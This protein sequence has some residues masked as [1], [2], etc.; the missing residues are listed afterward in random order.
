[1]A[2]SDDT[3]RTRFHEIR[4]RFEQGN[5]TGSGSAPRERRFSTGPAQA[6]EVT[7]TIQERLAALEQDKRERASRRSDQAI[8]I[9]AELEWLKGLK[10][11]SQRL[12]ALREKYA[13]ERAEKTNDPAVVYKKLH[14]VI[15][16]LVPTSKAW[17][18]ATYVWYGKRG[19]ALQRVDRGIEKVRA[20]LDKPTRI[21]ADDQTHQLLVASDELNNA[22]NAW[23][24]KKLK[25]SRDKFEA[26]ALELEDRRLQSAAAKEYYSNLRY[27][28]AVN[29]SF[30]ALLTRQPHAKVVEAAR[31]AEMTA[32]FSTLEFDGPSVQLGNLANAAIAGRGVSDAVNAVKALVKEGAKEV[33]AHIA[34]ELKQ[35]ALQQAV[36]A[37]DVLGVL[38]GVTALW[39]AYQAYAYL[40]TKQNMENKACTRLDD[41]MVLRMI[42]TLQS[43]VQL[44]CEQAAESAVVYA[45]AAATKAATHGAGA[46]VAEALKAMNKIARVVEQVAMTAYERSELRDI[47]AIDR[48]RDPQR[49]AE[50]VVSNVTLTC[51]YIRL[52]APEHL[53]RPLSFTLYQLDDGKA[54]KSLHDTKE[55]TEALSD[56]L[57][58][59]ECADE[60]LTS[61]N[62]ELKNLHAKAVCTTPLD[63]ILAIYSN[64]EPGKL[65]DMKNVLARKSRNLGEDLRQKKENTIASF[66]KQV[67]KMAQSAS[68]LLATASA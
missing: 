15:S 43:Q 12:A 38:D 25:V 19:D 55:L 68:Q 46:P 1:M 60:I 57:E 28:A 29:A 67:D 34:L 7:T 50:G 20:L 35:E 51:Y 58:L 33:S 61:W 45:A 53:L 3:P 48:T 47:N 52:A 31:V 8:A 59:K 21:K 26:A 37:L 44:Q 40:K 64:V 11:V 39:N 54:F 42:D 6:A 49:F 23:A 18:D 17:K 36:Q 9:G 4:R 16:G 30:T 56:V 63:D 27:L 14:G 62:T 2:E 13:T 41:G 24:A 66:R 65:K 22:V 32:L 10:L 5:V